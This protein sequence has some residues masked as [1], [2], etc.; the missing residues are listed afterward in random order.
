MG[1]MVLG[2]GAEV[3]TYHVGF[4]FY[5]ML[6]EIPE[7]LQL[8]AMGCLLLMV[9]ALGK[10]A[11]RWAASQEPELKPTRPAALHSERYAGD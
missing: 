7:P 6:S 9:S 1:Y 4:S 5:R 2:L 10:Q 11:I 8:I 3:T